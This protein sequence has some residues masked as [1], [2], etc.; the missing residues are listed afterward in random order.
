MLLRRSPKSVARLTA[1][2]VAK[3]ITQDVSRLTAQYVAKAITQD[4][5]KSIA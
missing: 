4:V 5:V 1:Q 2:Y 3:A